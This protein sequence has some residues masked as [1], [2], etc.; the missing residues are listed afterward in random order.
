MKLDKKEIESLINSTLKDINGDSIGLKDYSHYKG[1]V[2]DVFTLKNKGEKLLIVTSDRIS[3]FDK[4]LTTIPCKGEVLNKIS[5]FWFNELKS[6]I[7]NHIIK[8][9]SPRSVLTNKYDVLPIE[10]IVRGYLTGS[11]WRDYEKGNPISGIKLRDGM[12]FNEKFP[13]PIL[14]PSTKEQ[15]G[16]HDLPI[17]SREIVDK[18]IVPSHIWNKVE[19]AAKKLFI[20]G[21]EV[22]KK[23]GLILVDT[24]YEFGVKGNDV[25]LI[26]EVHTPDSSRF[27][28]EDTYKKLFTQGEKQR[29]LDKE[30]LRQWLMSKN[31]MGNGLIPDIPDDVRIE[32]AYRY[33]KAF[34]LITGNEFIPQSKNA[35][36][37]ATTIEESLKE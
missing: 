28:Y 37:E 20:R 1:K 6:I 5:L 16:A 7:P 29:K 2:R 31:Y 30:Y 25:F 35:K 13:E 3:A 8:Q 22:L 14:T 33:I 36:E 24:K 23:Q 11:A 34:E 27:W 21:T 15:K 9:T 18:G 19:D 17:S 4:V 26:D 32:V 12:K 10:V